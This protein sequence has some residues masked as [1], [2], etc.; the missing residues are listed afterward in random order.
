M[1]LI[2]SIQNDLGQSEVA[3][4]KSNPFILGII[5][6]IIPTATDDSEVA[7]CA[8]Y[9]AYKLYKLGVFELQDIMNHGK[10]LASSRYLGSL[11]KKSEEFPQVGD[12]ILLWRESPSSYKGHITVLS[13]D[14]NDSE[15]FFYGIGGNQKNRIGENTFVKD[16]IINVL[17]PEIK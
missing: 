2:E 15:L 7:W 1:E 5:K 16:R 11:L 4:K 6:W 8:I 9:L 14:F 17:K 3:G 13:R 10:K 12:I